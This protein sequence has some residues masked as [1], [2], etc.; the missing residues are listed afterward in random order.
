MRK[1]LLTLHL[2]AGCIAAL[3]FVILGVTGAMMVFEDRI[4]AAL[5]S[6]MTWVH[7]S[8]PRLRLTQIK[9]E[10]ERT[11]P[12]FTVRGFQIPPRD[13]ESWFAFLRKEGGGGLGLWYNPYTGEVLG[14]GEQRN[15][16]TGKL[17]QFHLRLLMGKVGREI[18][19]WAAP[20]LLLMAIS[21]IVLWWPRKIL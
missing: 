11:H 21:G 15:N 6:K 18:V 13:D 16:F 7:A 2:W 14:T 4:D 10:L 9:A 19:G 20:V 17:H 5:N 12:G 8:G 1:L 3:L